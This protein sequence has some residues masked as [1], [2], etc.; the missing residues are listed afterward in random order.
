M[1]TRGFPTKKTH[2]LTHTKW[3][4]KDAEYR[5]SAVSTP[6][7]GTRSTRRIFKT[8]GAMMSLSCSWAPDF[9][10]SKT[11]PYE[12]VKI[13]LLFWKERRLYFERL[14]AVRQRLLLLHLLPQF[15]SSVLHT[16]EESAHSII[17]IALA[18]KKQA[19]TSSATKR[20]RGAR[21]R[22]RHSVP[23]PTL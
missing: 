17:I 6:L 2:T 8:H 14:V 5:S 12:S 4:T 13:W 21:G 19:H 15:S 3:H 9:T 11:L 1:H 22:S 16:H 10:V 18:W 20:A 7:L 23:L